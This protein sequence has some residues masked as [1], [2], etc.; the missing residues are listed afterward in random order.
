MNLPNKITVAR[1]LLIF[2]FL[3]LASTGDINDTTH[4]T[5]QYWCHFSAYW[6]AFFAACT[7]FVDGWL[8]RRWNMVTNFGALMDPLADKIYDK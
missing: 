3:I 1:I 7:D 2:V 5:W 4:E 8:A 6:I